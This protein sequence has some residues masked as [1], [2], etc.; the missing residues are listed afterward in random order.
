MTE[1]WALSTDGGAT[2]GGGELLGILETH[3][4]RVIEGWEGLSPDDWDARSRNAGWT[5][6]ETARHVADAMTVCS[7][8]LCGQPPDLPFAGFD[9]LETPDAWIARSVDEPPAATIERFAGAADLLRERV[10][11]RSASGDASS[12]RTPYGPAHWTLSVVHVFWD[13]WLHERDVLLPLGRRADSSIDEQRLVG[14]YGLLVALVPARMVG[15]EVATSV[16]FAGSPHRDVTAAFE[17]GRLTAAETRG[18]EPTLQGDVATVTDAL[19]GRGIPI[20]E[21]LPGAPDELAIL[22]NHFTNAP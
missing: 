3:H 10:G 1:L 20:A 11:E 9:P 8:G 16:R 6:H 2:L 21:A 7:A 17:A 14:L 4:A 18:I 15:H 13:S 19:S 12:L 22:A 5:V